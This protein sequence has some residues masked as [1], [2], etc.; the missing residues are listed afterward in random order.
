MLVAMIFP[1]DE[2]I[3]ECLLKKDGNTRGQ[4]KSYSY[5]RQIALSK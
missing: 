2:Q 1:D 5:I 3:V 4:V